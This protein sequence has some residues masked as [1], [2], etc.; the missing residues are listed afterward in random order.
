MKTKIKIFAVL[1]SIFAASMFFSC[2]NPISLGTKLDLLGPVVTI[3]SPAQRQSVPVRFDIEGTVQDESVVDILLIT[4]VKDNQNFPRQWRYKK[5]AWEVSDNDGATWSPLTG[6][7]WVGDK[8]VTWK[9]TIDMV[10]DGQ[11]SAEGEVTFNVQAWDK[12][13]MSDDNSFKALVLIVDIDPP[14]VIITN[15]YLYGKYAYQTDEDFKKFDAM[16]DSS[17]EWKDP[18]YLGKFITQEFPLK[19]QIEDAND[20]W[21]I[22]I[23]FYPYNTEIDNAPETPLP[24]NYIFRYYK[25]LPPPPAGANPNDYVR[26]NG[27]VTVPDLY[28]EPGIYDEGGEL[29][30]PVSEKM[31]VK[32]VAVCYDAA[33]NPNQEKT[34]GYFIS[35]PRANSPWIVFTEGIEP[36]DNYYDKQVAVDENN[37]FADYIEKDVFTVY[38]G[39]SVKATAFQEHGVKEVKYSLYKCD[40]S[41]NKLNRPETHP[42]ED[43]FI[44]EEKQE[45]IVKSN[46][47]YGGTYSTIFPWEIKVPPL[48]GYY[49]F[50]AEAFSSQDKP[51]EK[52]T[53]LFRVHDITFPDF[54]EGPF[55]AATDPLFLDITNNK[56]TIHGGVSDATN[57]VSLCMVWINPE[58]KDFAAMSQLAY[59]RDK[60]YVGWKKALNLSAGASELENANDAYD[61]NHLNRL[62]MLNLKPDVP[63]VDNVTNRRRFTYSQVIDLTDDLNIAANKQPLKS[64]IFLLRAQNPDGKCTIITYAPQGDTLAPDI[65][66]TNMTIIGIDNPFIPNEYAVIPKFR[67]GNTIT[68]NGTWREDSLEILS[69]NDYF[70]TNFNINVNNQ[71]LPFP[72]LTSN[73]DKTTGTWTITATVKDTPGGEG[74]IALSALKDTLVIGASVKD[75]GGNVAEAGCSWL[76]E[77]DNLRLMRISSEIDDGIYTVGKQIDIFL[78]FSKSVRLTTSGN[79]PELILSSAGGNTAR[80]VYKDGQ[81]NQNSRQYFTYTVGAGQNAIADNYLNV[82]GIYFNG[83]ANESIPYNTINYPFSWSRGSLGVD[84]YEEVRITMAKKGGVSYDGNTKEAEGYYLRTLPITTTSTDPDYQFTLTAGK[85]IEIDTAVPSITSVT[86]S[87]AGYHNSGD[88]YI[89]VKFNKAVTIPVAKQSD[90]PNVPCLTLNVTNGANNTVQTSADA[91][92]V[93]VNGSDITFMYSIIKPGDTTNG[94]EVVVSGLSGIITDIA[95]NEFTYSGGNRTLSGIYIETLNPSPP[96]VRVL[97]ANETANDANVI[98][99]NVSGITNQ[100]LSTSN[101]RDLSNVYQNNLWLAIERSGTAYK[102]SGGIEYSLDNGKNWV[103]APNTDNTPFSLTKIGD[104]TL[105]ARQIDAA[106][107]R[108]DLTSPITFYWDPGTLISRISSTNANGTY[109]NVAGSSNGNQI[110]FTVYFRK[111]ICIAAT[112]TPQITLQNVVAYNNNPINITPTSIPGGAVNS[113][114]FTYTV[115]FDSVSKT[116]DKMSDGA[117]LDIGAIS[118]ITA[119]DGTAVGN[120][121]NVSSLINMSNVS[122]KLEST[123]QFTVETGDLT[124]TTP[125]FEEDYGAESSADFHGIRSDDGSYWTTLKIQFN[126]AITKGSGTITIQQIAGSGNS[127]YRMPAVLTESQYN[128]FKGNST[129]SADIDKYYIKGTNGYDNAT[130]SSD[131]TTKYILQYNYN[132]DSNVTGNDSAFT[133]DAFIPSAFISAFRNAEAISINVN[134]QAVTISGDGK[135]LNIRL[136]GSSAPQVPG[137]SYEITYPAGLVADNLGNV[138]AEGN[139]TGATAIALRGIAKPFVRIRKTQDTITVSNSYSLAQPRLVA[140][141]PLQSYARMDCRTPNA[142]ITYVATTY[143]NSNNADVTARNWGTGLSTTASGANGYPAVNIN[144]PQD[145]ANGATRPTNVAAEAVFDYTYSTQITLGDSNYQGYQWW[146]LAKARSGATPYAYSAVTEEKAYRTVITYQLRRNANTNPYNPGPITIGENGGESL[147][148]SGDQVWI[149]G[150][151]AIGSSSIPGFPFTWEDNWSGDFTNKRA[152]IRLMTLTEATSNNMNQSIWKFV[153]WEINTTAY[154]DFIRGKDA[155]SSANQAWQYGPIGSAYQRSGWTSHKDKYPIYPGKH[156]WCDTANDWAGL[157]GM[158]FSDTF[159]NRP[160]VAPFDDTNY[161]R[162]PGIN[163]E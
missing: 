17:D 94:N 24:E 51:S 66:I 100:G 109:T 118:G 112:P 125:G 81:E 153:T 103:K 90:P 43:V 149:R 137:A 41:G 133:G 151:D 20:V 106:G 146:V 35:W 38:P 114:T 47:A 80:A 36:P 78:E 132:P 84:G 122:P 160:T 143:K 105:I 88:I 87:D 154:V 126:R 128:R 89:T 39:R 93:R 116:G 4:A 57:V 52:Y 46:T 45:N 107:N 19:W 8:F 138:S 163:S 83:V 148:E 68:I 162:W 101:N 85:H 31:T 67:D 92:D 119:W 117:Y 108:S 62:W 69:I 144:G 3:V 130:G 127:A 76:I 96:T 53:M 22:N 7:S 150:G 72:V 97:T 86:S 91:K 156:R 18:S 70:K 1:L 16:P 141:Q 134:S 5:G 44:D 40:I 21:S 50:T 37:P 64:Q 79:K 65:K 99:Q 58:S 121:V 10:I 110:A 140:V 2:E 54:T 13:G 59:F 161:T 111:N 104:N 131:T 55:P 147:L 82:I 30:N 34:L 75:I 115:G 139:Y 61:R 77:S 145:T 9:I 56:I 74:Q 26:L 32:V 42:F 25:N 159:H 136:T 124:N 23:S 158:S 120:G 155:S 48:T 98:L 129:L 71:G 95:G 28:D 142:T 113:L 15:P 14:K 49:V 157:Y 60:D 63:P 12:G 6:A 33:G 11:L 102:Y 123:K 29:K 73:A 135:T 152:G 27:A